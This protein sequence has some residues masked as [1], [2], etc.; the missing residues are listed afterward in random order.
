PAVLPAQPRT[1]GGR[2]HGHGGARVRRTDRPRATYGVRAG[3]EPTHRA[4]DGRSGWLRWPS[5]TPRL[6]PTDR[7]PPGAPRTDSPHVTQKPS[8]FRPDVMRNGASP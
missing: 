2:S 4:A 8:S 6:I 7:C 5:P 1:D 3:A